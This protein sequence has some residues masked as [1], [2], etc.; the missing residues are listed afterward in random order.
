MRCTVGFIDDM[1]LGGNVDL[2]ESRKALQRDLDRL[3]R[4]AEKNSSPKEW[5]GTNGLR[6][7][8]VQEMCRC[9]T[10]ER[11]LVGSVGGGWMVGLDDL[12]GL[13]QP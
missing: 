5:S 12:G 10:K 7:K 13:F 6:R 11:G 2:L 3:D 4:W 9:G 1:K 8:V